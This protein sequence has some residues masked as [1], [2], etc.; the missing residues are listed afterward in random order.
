MDFTQAAKLFRTQKTSD[1][2]GNKM[3]GEKYLSF[4][5]QLAFGIL[6]NASTSNWKINKNKQIIVSY[7]FVTAGSRIAGEHVP[8]CMGTSLQSHH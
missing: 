1:E 2:H 4:A 7:N 3:S 6:W 8:D 5:F